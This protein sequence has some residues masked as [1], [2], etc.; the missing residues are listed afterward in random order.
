MRKTSCAGLSIVE[1]LVA[2][3]I[4]LITLGGVYQIF[5]SNTLTYRM[6]EGLARV[7]ENGRFAMEFLVND[8][9][10]AG[11]LGCIANVG[12]F[13]NTL[14]STAYVYD[15][16]VGL[17]GFESQNSTWHTSV[18]SSIVEPLT[19]SDIVT[20]RKFLGSAVTIKESMPSVSAELKTKAIPSGT[21]PVVNTDDIVLISDCTSNAAVFQITNYTPS[22]GNM[23]HEINS[24]GGTANPGNHTET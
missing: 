18:D 1:A 7:Q 9:R 10:M 5:Q 4:L 12:N 19:G 20:I 16:S 2:M 3:V 13:V 11:Y 21:T 24:G 22:N 6:Q 14:D 15:F 17:F 23:E 8:I